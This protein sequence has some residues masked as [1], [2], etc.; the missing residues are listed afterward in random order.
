MKNVSGLLQILRL[1][2]KGEIYNTYRLQPEQPPRYGF[3]VEEETAEEEGEEHYE[4]A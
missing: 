4:H 2:K 3:V 1:G